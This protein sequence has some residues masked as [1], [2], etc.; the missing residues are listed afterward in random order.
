MCGLLTV[1]VCKC[2][3]ILGNS[4]E[5]LTKALRKWSVPETIWPAGEDGWAEEVEAPLAVIHHC[6]SVVEALRVALLRMTNGVLHKAWIRT[7]YHCKIKTARCLMLARAKV[8]R[9]RN[10]WRGWTEGSLVQLLEQFQSTLTRIVRFLKMW[11][12]LWEWVLFSF[13]QFFV[14]LELTCISVAKLTRVHVESTCDSV[15]EEHDST[16]SWQ[17]S[18]EF[19]RSCG[20]V[21]FFSTGSR[22][23]LFLARSAVT[24]SVT[25]LRL[26][27]DWSWDQRKQTGQ[28]CLGGSCQCL[29]IQ[30]NPMGEKV[31]KQLK[32]W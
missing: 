32:T 31:E 18:R 10:Q 8:K 3:H 11:V 25:A 21:R 4:R 24:N 12:L 23:T 29:G 16:L 19:Q 5:S 7:V 15:H 30:L 28:L 14:Y 6:V 17:N 1:S 27:K 2:V 26:K 20:H 9:D 13:F 22:R